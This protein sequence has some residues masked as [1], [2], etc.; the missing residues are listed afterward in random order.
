MS[1]RYDKAFCALLTLCGGRAMPEEEMDVLR[2]LAAWA[3]YVA[4]ASHK[5]QNISRWGSI[6]TLR[7]F[8]VKI[9][10]IMLKER[11]NC[12]AG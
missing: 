3:L 6:W 10:L 8:C 12:E 2:F 11:G 5:S 9:Y 4:A 7:T 1:M